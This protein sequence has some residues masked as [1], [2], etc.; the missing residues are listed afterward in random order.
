ME[1]INK[2]NSK[3]LF[4]CLEDARQFVAAIQS[5]GFK[6]SECAKNGGVIYANETG[7]RLFVAVQKTIR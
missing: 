3:H 4:N 6:Y 7:Y 5:A 1:R 2:Y